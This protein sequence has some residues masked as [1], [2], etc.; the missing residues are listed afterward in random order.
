MSMADTAL[1]QRTG[2]N[3]SDDTAE[4]AS[5]GTAPA[6][7]HT[8]AAPPSITWKVPGRV[9]G[10]MPGVGPRFDPQVKDNG[11]VWWYV[12]GLS[13][14]GNY[15]FTVIAFIGSV[16]SPY[17]KWAR[18]GN[19]ADPRNYSCMHVVLYGRSDRRW[20]MTERKADAL[21]QSEDTLV[22][23]PSSLHWDGDKL[24][25][26][27]DEVSNPLPRRVRGRITVHTDAV[28]DR[29]SYL[30][31][32]RAQ[33]WW[34]INPRARAEVNLDTPGI[35]WSGNAYFDSNDGDKPL[36]DSFIYWNW[37]RGTLKDGGAAILYDLELKDGGFRKLSLRYRPDGT[38]E[39]FTSPDPMVTLPKTLWQ[40]A[41][42]TR[43][44]PGDNA[45][46]EERLVDTPFYSR[47][48]LRTHLL[49]QPVRAMHESLD[50]R[51]FVSPAVQF[52]LPFKVPRRFV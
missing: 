8:A 47:S 23:G 50:M 46:I 21:S 3:S 51:R 37:S 6:P 19:P 12:D 11:Y 25:I 22:I 42:H 20:A 32:E 18:R 15:G 48:V 44:D 16:F 52:L 4:A 41:R 10:G 9:G 14:D 1:H 38:V 29:A 28:Y 36:E 49:G 7:A 33:R 13:D 27:L 17:Y 2:H 39:D 35:R 31:N 26:D 45:H 24:T 34:P 43:C 30:D 40:V 5:G